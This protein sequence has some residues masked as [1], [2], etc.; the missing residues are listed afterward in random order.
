MGPDASRGGLEP[1]VEAS[2]RAVDPPDRE[3]FA[4]FAR[5]LL[6]GADSRT[7]RTR[8]ATTLAEV[9]R[10]SFPLLLQ[11]APGEI[12]ARVFEPNDRPGRT[13][14]EVLQDDR[15]FLVDT[16]RLALR[17]HQLAEQILLH[18]IL[19]VRRDASAKLAGIGDG[20]DARR[21]SFI[22]V[23]VFPPLESADERAAFESDLRSS[24]ATVADVTAD[25]RR[26]IRAVRELWANVEYAG[27]FVPDGAERAAK[28]CR[29]LDWLVADH[30]V[31]MG[32]RSYDIAGSGDGLEV[33]LRRGSGLGM[34]RDDATSRFVEPERGA[35]VPEEIHRIV[36]DPRIILISKARIESKIHRAGRLD[37]VLLK[38]HDETGR[39]SGF[40]IVS[41]L[42]TS[43][44]LRTPATQVPLLAERLEA[45]LAQ[46][47]A[48]PGS[49]RH[50]AIVA[51]FD[52]A[53][54]EFLLS[55]DVESNAALVRE[56]VAAEG[57]EEARLVLRADRDERSYYAAVLLPRERYSEEARERIRELLIERAGASY[58]D[59]RVSFLEEGTAVLHFFCVLAEGASVPTQTEPLEAAIEAVSA[60]WEDRFLD[61][62]IAERGDADG[63]ALAARYEP[64][65][66]AAHRVTTDP[67]DALR[68]VAA[69]ERL[70]AEGEPQFALY[71]ER[72]AADPPEST[73]LRIYLAS[74]RLLSDLLPVVDH[75]GIRVVDARQTEVA[76]RDRPP[77]VIHTLRVLPLG[78]DQADLDAIAPRLSAALAAAL[79]REV[80]D[81]PLNGLVLGAGLDWREIDLVRAYLEYWNQIQGA[82]TRP[83]VRSVLLENP[84]AVRILVQYHDARLR[85]G[86]PQEE[87]AALEAKHRKGF[88][89]YRDR[90]GALNEDRALG[91]L[92]ELIDATLR[93]SFFRPAPA[94]WRLSFKLDP[95]RLPGLKPPQPFREIFV[96]AA[97][98]DGI[99]LRGGS[100]ARGGIRWSDRLDDFRTEVHGLMRTQMLKNGLIV[101]VGA[102]GG[103][104]LPRG[105]LSAREARAFADAQYRVFIAGL[106]D[107]T[108]DLD[109]AGKIVPPADVHRRDGDDPYLVVAADKGTA[110]LSDAANAIALERDFWL[111]DAFASGG[112]EGYDHKEL[113]ITARGAWE[114]VKH[115]LAELGIDPDRDAY[116]VAGIGDMSGDVFGNGLLLAR[117]AR[118]LAAFDHRHVFLD[119]DPD[120]AIAWAERKRLFDLPGSSWADYD[121]AKISAGGGVWPRG[122]KKI[123]VPEP[124]RAKLGLTAESVTGHELVRAILAAPVDL[125][126]NGGIGTYVKAGR[127]THAEV[128]DRA[129]DTVRIDAGELR[130]RVVGE[131][132]NLGFTQEARV[133]AALRGVRLDSDA[134]HNSGGVDLSDH[135]VNYKVLLAPLVRSGA[136]SPAGRHDA[137]FGAVDDACESVLAHN[138]SQVLCLSLDERRAKSDAQSFLWAAE[139]LCEST[140]NKRE[141]L[142]LPDAA[143]VAARRAQGLALVRPELSVLIGLA[144]LHTRGAL[145][146]DALLDQPAF[147]PLVESYFPP[148]WREQWPGAVAD[149]RLRREI[150]AL[151]ATN[152]LVDANGI[153]LIPSLVARRGLPVAKAVAAALF[154]E[155]ILDAP[156]TRARLLEGFASLPREAVY[157]SLIELSSAVADVARY[158]L[159]AGLDTLDEKTLVRWRTGLLALRDSA[160]DF[161]SASE[162]AQWDER[163]RRLAETGLPQEL[164]TE[165][166]AL[167]LADRALNIVRIL[168]RT[169]LAPADVGR[170]YARLGEGTGLNGVYQRLPAAEAADPWDR[171]VVSD[172]RTQLLDL[173]R[174]LTETVL[175]EKPADPVAATD[176]F[177]SDHAER[178]ARVEALQ[179]PTLTRASASSLSVVTQALLRL[180]DAL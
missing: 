159:A 62:L 71:F 105:G 116:T 129:N 68:D 19:P 167:P 60:R 130:A 80:A 48:A 89:T 150:T 154:A 125:L 93:T 56:M 135:E 54:V 78:G 8:G 115:H 50:K 102:K 180:R 121:K 126:W 15:P 1:A 66:P 118:L 44:A 144:K 41:G 79:R 142:E 122:A 16:V 173:Q 146:G 138:R 47:Q 12:A 24:L 107:L 92:Y 110:H 98:V 96:H 32:V 27:R 76:P 77:A 14:V 179:Q 61:A 13:V 35:R 58:V 20:A 10:Q 104:V 22:Y 25:Y 117:N 3:A 5:A 156:A 90:I 72:G 124:A 57:A 97:E 127:E 164:A 33:A 120:P 149:H 42:F 84:L 99:H 95:R 34:W 134:I 26:M 52:S 108:D 73:T 45:I 123:V 152:R 111:G 30:F 113:A 31:F 43:R 137:L 67:V 139:S 74:P 40:T 148:R 81:D 69:L 145:N 64:A 49:H 114:C 128:G 37:R 132:G 109:D 11:R 91:A 36:G 155:E 162:A 168:E 119:P 112:S 171:M 4:A 29:F 103:F 39:V 85:P 51:A 163:R 170:V 166:A 7:V 23:E 18:P 153:T 141:E 83:F 160:R 176:A 70:H 151:V 165:I 75:F 28:I 38:Q 143:T 88:A 9:A 94:P 161:L 174:E 158:L 136:L 55:S 175:A 172:L 133:E 178:I 100:V 21:E 65:L 2:A 177:L 140:G 87:R 17:R 169:Q 82:L 157:A 59:D 6:G 106:L 101:P 63:P 147:R 131:G 46:E 86:R 53:P